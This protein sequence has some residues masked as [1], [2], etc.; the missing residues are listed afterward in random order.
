MQ[1]QPKLLLT[2]AGAS[3]LVA[4]I[5]GA[6]GSHALA[7]ADER[8]LQSF[9]TAVEFQFFHGLG[10]IAVTLVGLENRGG[11]LRAA[12]A[13]LMAVGTVLFCGSIYAKALGAPAGITAAAPYGGVA[14]ML[15]WLLFAAS[16][17]LPGAPVAR[18]RD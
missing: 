7:F 11:L 5:A 15:G 12:T 2:F 4:A 13:W 10:V 9:S 17:W 14:F 1:L 3:L 18:P 6:V 8:A 16:V